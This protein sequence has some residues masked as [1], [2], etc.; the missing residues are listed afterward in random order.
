M[1]WIKRDTNHI[2]AVKDQ[3]LAEIEQEEWNPN[4]LMSFRNGTFDNNKQEFFKGL[5][6]RKH[7]LT[8]SFDFNYSP[9]AKC[10][11]WIKF[12]N[13]TF[14]NNQ[15]VIEL[16]KASFKWT[17][18]PKDIERAF[19]LDLLF[20][21]HG[22]KGSGKGTTLEVLQALCGGKDA[23]GTLR[24]NMLNNRNA[25]FVLIGKKL[26]FDMDASG[27]IS[28]AG[29]LNNIITNEPVPVEKKYF[30]IDDARLGVVYWRAFNNN[31]TVSGE[32]VEGLG[33]RMVTFKFPRSAA[34]P[35]PQLKNKLLAEIEGIFWWCWSMDD[36]KMFSV[37]KNRGNIQSYVDATLENLLDNQPILQF[38]YQ[39]DGE[40]RIQSSV[41]YKKYRDWCDEVGKQ[42][43]SQTKFGIELKKMEGFVQKEETSSCNYYSISKKEEI[44]LAQFFGIPTNGKL[45]PPSGKVANPNPPSSNPP[46]H[47][48]TENSMEGMEGSNTKNSF[49]NK[50]EST[51][52]EKKKEETLQTLQPSIIPE[53]APT[54]SA[55]DTN[56]DDDD[57]YWG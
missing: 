42:S 10:P 3:L 51:Y 36:N 24:T 25:L 8:H 2:N 50:K 21:L 48:G 26:A 32:A 9:D 1:G 38:I 27:H 18:S 4:H 37:L 16:L 39:L 7:Y 30:D 11:T 40:Y 49:K 44:N 46:T 20:D 5:H 47:L 22:K 28:D 6:D 41:L 53:K 57:P 31:P 55:W 34:K 17:I 15:E 12:L 19:M 54:G 35:D 13:E 52:I 14:N 33:R 23:C 43:A 29:I 56:S 45:N